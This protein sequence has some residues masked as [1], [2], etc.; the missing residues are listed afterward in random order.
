MCTFE[1]KNVFNDIQIR[2]ASSYKI[3]VKT[4]RNKIVDWIFKLIYGYK[5]ESYFPEG[6]DVVCI[7]K[8]LYVRDKATLEK[9]LKDCNVK[10]K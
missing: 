2:L 7:G 5:E 9:I 4:H 8:V 3:R 6:C 1:K 10:I